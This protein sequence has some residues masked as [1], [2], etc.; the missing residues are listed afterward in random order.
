VIAAERAGADDG[1]A[2][3]GGGH[4]IKLSWAVRAA[5]NGSY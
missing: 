1:E 3:F 5:S 2:F 4:D